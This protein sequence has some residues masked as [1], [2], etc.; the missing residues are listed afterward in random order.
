[1]SPNG[2]APFFSVGLRVW[3]KDRQ[4]R[5]MI[6]RLIAEDDKTYTLRQWINE[7][8]M[9]REVGIEVV[10]ERDPVRFRDQS[11]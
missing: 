10:R 2:P 6:K 9:D 7:A 3:V 1:M 8:G 11:Q 5:S 4:K